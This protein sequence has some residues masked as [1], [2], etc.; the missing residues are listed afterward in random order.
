[1][2]ETGVRSLYPR[3]SEDRLKA[4]LGDTPVV[5]L[6]GPRQAGK[7]TLVQQFSIVDDRTYLTLD[8]Q[9]VLLSAKRDPEGLVSSR[10]RFTIDEIQRAPDLLL[11][12]KKSVDQD[13]RPGRFLLT[14]SADIIT[15]PTVSES[16][17]G[18]MEIISLLPL[19]RAEITATPPSFL[20]MAFDGRLPEISLGDDG[21]SIQDSVLTGGYPELLTRTDPERR[22]RWAKS[23]LDALFSRDVG[24]I[25]GIEKH[26][27]LSRLFRLVV[28][29]S[30][31][32][33]NFTQWGGTLGLN[34]KTAK[35][36]VFL[37]EQLFLV[38][39]LE[40]WQ[41]NLSSRILKS[42]RIYAL[43]SGL[44]SLATGLTRERLDRDRSLYGSLLETFVVSEIKKQSEWYSESLFLSHYRDKEQNEVDLLC[45][46]RS[47]RIVA[48]EIK[49]STN[50]TPEDLRGLRKL[51][52]ILGE[53]LVL[54]LI[55]HEGKL[56]LPLGD[57]I[58]AA[59]VSVLW[60]KGG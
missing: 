48:V 24:E 31:Q 8:D 17:A 60:G 50:V 34:D 36:Y 4:A 40:P 23:Y 21:T 56:T 45:E 1:M 27:T 19:S 49:A 5:L 28:S 57:N 32:I 51:R 12:I 6:I 11:A 35:Q 13:R 30:G 33:P 29:R 44:Q 14:G 39:R 43:D 26:E 41:T 42:P 22:M 25:S 58:Y 20:K 10:Q 15:L 9:N 52:G 18:R 2:P 55:L 47:G 46:D 3:F 16:L 7:S 54:G 59:P 37:L 38:H 53:Q